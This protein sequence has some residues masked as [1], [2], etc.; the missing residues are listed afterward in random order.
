MFY[1][2]VIFYFLFILFLFNIFIMKNIYFLFLVVFLFGFTGISAQTYCFT[3]PQGYAS[4]TTGGGSGNVTIV[5]SKSQLQSALT[6]S[7]DGI[8]I[9]KGSVQCDYLSVLVK[10][11]T[12]LGLPGAKLYTNDQTSGKSGILYI[13][14]GSNNVIIRNLK[15]VGPGAYDSDGRDC[16]TNEGTKVWVDHC[17]FQDGMDGNYDNKGKADNVTVTWCK[18]TYLKPPK[19]GGSGGT[20]DHR[21]SNLVGSSSSNY[22][23]DRQ[24]SI[25]WQYCWWADG[26]VE[27]MVRARNAQLHM[28]NCYWNSS[29]AKKCIGL[30]DGSN[31]NGTQVY[32]EGGVFETSSSCKNIDVSYGGSPDITVKDCIG[33]NLSNHSSTV[34]KPSYSYSALSSSK[35]KAA[36][37][38]SCG[39]GATL[40]IT[41]TGQIS[42]LCGTSNP[43]S[44]TGVSVSPTSSTIT[45]AN[46]TVQL[47]ATVTPSN[48]SDKSASW[49]SS[50]TSVATV[51]STGLVTG[52]ANGTATITV[53]TNDAGKKATCAI[54]VNI[55]STP[56][57]PSTDNEVHNFTESGISSSFYS[58]SGNLS[59]SKGTVTYNGLPLTQCLKIESSTSISFTAAQAGT[60]T[61]VFNSN[62]TGAIKADGA[63]CA[64]ASSGVLTE[65]L[66]AGKHTL[67]KSSTAN[68]YYISYGEEL[69]SASIS[70][71][72][73]KS[74]PK[75]D[76]N[77][78]PN[79]VNS[80]L[81]IE[82]NKELEK[83]ALIQLFDIAGKL[84][85]NKN[86]EGE[87]QTLDMTDLHSGLYILKVTN[88]NESITKRI[89]KQ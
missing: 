86:V 59:T 10:N 57:T 31:G 21:Y 35:V 5:T 4:G 29:V 54:T 77:S 20:D 83:G 30:E 84:I 72:R 81:T 22:P 6:A 42:S 24:Y 78:Y 32:L 64:N 8:V 13:K 49:T 39:A 66:S 58:I 65:N 41:S 52:K 61:L 38:S 3:E 56:P 23:S 7:G 18:F 26:C 28:L 14:P 12:L 45:T 71:E 73:Q 37:T 46:G 50:N 34:S 79:P 55:G 1:T 15:F 40:N 44:V 43:V 25:T 51:S 74:N 89:I 67:T 2:F 9:V 70:S 33:N 62:Y 48:A 69:K 53:K 75:F 87:K 88:S 76:F 27:R 60:L 36:V 17:E 68:L 16:L 11:K 47:S 85:T 80:L 19:A 82:F 63:T